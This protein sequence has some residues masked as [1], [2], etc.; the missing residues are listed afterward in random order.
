MSADDIKYDCTVDELVQL[1]ECRGLDSVSE[2][3]GKYGGP[4]QLCDRLKTSYNQGLCDEKDIDARRIYFGSNFI[5]AKP[6]K[7]FLQLAFEAMQDTTLMVLIVAAVISLGLSFYPKSSQPNG[8][9]SDQKAEWIEAV[10][11][12]MAIVV[13]VLVTAGN[14]YSKEKQFRGLQSTIEQEQKFTVLRKGK[15]E[16]ILVSDIVVGDIC[17]VKYGDLIPADGI[18]IQCNDLKIDESAL[19]G[20]SDL[21]RKGQDKDI[22]VLAGTHVMEGSGKVVVTAV[23]INSQSGIIMKL[24]GVAKIA[25]E[26]KKKGK[27]KSTRAEGTELESGLV[28]NHT[29]ENLEKLKKVKDS[30]EVGKKEKSVLQAKLTRLAKQIGYAGTIVAVMTVMALVTR[31]CIEEFTIKKR[32]FQVED[33]QVLIQYIII[34][35]TV[36]VIAVPEG[37]PLAVT[38]SL[39]YSVKKMMRDNNLVRHLYAC[40]TMGNATAICSDK[41]GTLTTNSMTVVQSYLAG[42]HY[43]TTPKWTQLPELIRHMLLYSIS[44]N[45]GYSSQV[46]V[47]A[48]ESH[49]I[50]QQGNKTECALLGLLVEFGQNYQQI[51]DLFPEETFVKVY[52]FNSV[53]KSMTTVIKKS[54]D[55]GGYRVFSKGA[56][57]VILQKCKYILTKDGE[58]Q[59]LPPKMQ[60]YIIKTVVVAMAAAGLRTICL[61]YK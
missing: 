52:T 41:T 37:L 42:E 48:K 28:T 47:Q 6:P 39:A 33:I 32:S 59:L 43:R 30:A 21:I 34:G 56:S 5:P 46:V 49:Q 22:L 24:L 50:K 60:K 11:I 25:E 19:T 40:E 15:P 7:T 2:L 29:N 45:S 58:P 3:R 4:A 38:L 54:D 53:R 44:I 27:K 23:G 20:E 36:L 1:M 18:I 9:P 8:N 57:E 26:D 51:R 16:Q 17:L 14:N 12:F 55:Q 13:V 10:A 35:I 61:A 31:F